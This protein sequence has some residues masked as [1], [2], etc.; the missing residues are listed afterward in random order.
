[1]R[2]VVKFESFPCPVVG[3]TV[4]VTVQTSMLRGIGQPTTTQVERE[5]ENETECWGGE[6]WARCPVRLE[7]LAGRD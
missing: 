2:S 6:C 1:M 4:C 3:R 5:C 7:N